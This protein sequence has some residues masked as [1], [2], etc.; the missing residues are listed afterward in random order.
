M[1][2]VLVLAIVL[3]VLTGYFVVANRLVDLK[4]RI[5]RAWSNIDVLLEQRHDE[6]PQLVEVCRGHM[7][8]EAGL[9]NAL[10]TNSR[11]YS[12]GQTVTDKV[13]AGS[14]VTEGLQQLFALAEGYP[15]LRA[16]ESF[17]YLRARI[18]SLEAQIAD[19]R[20]FFNDSVYIYNTRIGQFPFAAIA[21]M[22]N[23][24]E[25]PLWGR[26]GAGNPGKWERAS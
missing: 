1:I 9:L 16:N 6:I 5:S 10:V 19:R 11:S 12:A 23:L 17:A 15:E 4:N 22:M 21:G 20:E 3:M 24:Q 26:R 25:L 2:F 18:S 7:K 8:H 13:A 14:A